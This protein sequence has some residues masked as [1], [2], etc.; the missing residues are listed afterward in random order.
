MPK[1]KKGD[2]IVDLRNGAYRYVLSGLYYPKDSNETLHYRS[3]LIKTSVGYIWLPNV[4]HNGHEF[5][6][7]YIEA[8]YRLATSKEIKEYKLQV[9]EESLK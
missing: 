1:F 4:Y 3:K 7:S 5:T 8:R 6:Q 2:I 9:F